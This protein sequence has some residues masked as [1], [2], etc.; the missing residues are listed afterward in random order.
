MTTYT[1]H[2]L[3]CLDGDD[4]A[5]IALAM[6]TDALAVDAALVDIDTDLSNYRNRIWWNAVNTSS[7]SVSSSGGG[8]YAEG[9]VGESTPGSGSATITAN[10][11]SPILGAQILPT[12][13][14]LMGT[15]ANWTVAT[16]NNNTTR[17]LMVYDSKFSGGLTVDDRVYLRVTGEQSTG[18][19]SA[20]VSGFFYSDGVLQTQ[21]LGV[22]SH[23]N[24][25]SNIVVAAGNWRTWFMYMGSGLVI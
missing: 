24:T 19:G 14:Y 18:G 4:Y 15:T 16:P 17:T 12:G 21:V 22:L 20:D 13:W 9:I 2:G 25:S 3:V 6:R 7:I 8:V 1:D 11:V 10:G 23:A 5:A